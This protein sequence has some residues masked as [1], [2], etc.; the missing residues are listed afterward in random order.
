MLTIPLLFHPSGNTYSFAAIITNRS[1]YAEDTSIFE[2]S[3]QATGS[4]GLK[5]MLLNHN[6]HRN[7]SVSLLERR[8]Y[9]TIDDG[10]LLKLFT[11]T[12]MLPKLICLIL[13][14]LMHI[15]HLNVLEGPGTSS[16]P[17]AKVRT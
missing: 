10:R 15:L 13:E 17:S 7:C 16:L 11:I 8:I 1:K 2:L 4:G 14:T 6:S 3:D 5:A 12:S 9:N